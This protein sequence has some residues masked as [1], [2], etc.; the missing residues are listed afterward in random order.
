MSSRLKHKQRS[1]KT[2]GKNVDFRPFVNKANAKKIRTEN[3][4][5]FQSIKSALFRRKTSKES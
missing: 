3:K 4:S 1:H 2:Y 5:F